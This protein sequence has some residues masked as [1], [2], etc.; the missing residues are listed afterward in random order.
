VG[1]TCGPREY[2]VY[3]G[4]DSLTFDEASR[5]FTV[6]S[7]EPSHTGTHE[8]LL[9]V[10]LKNY[11]QFNPVVYRLVSFDVVI[12]AQCHYTQFLYTEP[13]DPFT[14]IINSAA[15][16]YTIDT[17]DDQVSLDNPS[18]NDGHSYCRAREIQFTGIE[19]LDGQPTPADS[20]ICFD[21]ATRTFSLQGSDS[22]EYG[23][24]KVKFSVGLAEYPGLVPQENSIEV[25]VVPDCL[26]STISANGAI[27]FTRAATGT[28]QTFS[29]IASLF[30][31]D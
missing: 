9:L 27:V 20:L 22:S 24:Y 10:Q 29:N 6:S 25:R 14:H 15:V 13:A 2:L 1:D 7:T 28:T 17:I 12:D 11:P 30:S 26:S 16:T 23:R 3:Q 18:F 19:P 21:G 31:Y 4:H 5:T 8:I